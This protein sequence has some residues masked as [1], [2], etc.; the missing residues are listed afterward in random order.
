M[1]DEMLV[2]W[3][4]EA[5][6]IA[7]VLHRLRQAQELTVQEVGEFAGIAKSYVSMLER[8]QKMPERDTLVALLLASFSLPVPLAN[9]ILVFAGFAPMH[10]KMLARRVA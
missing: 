10:H 2:R 6:S 4:V 7:D 8:G 9:R 3:L 5:E 1:T